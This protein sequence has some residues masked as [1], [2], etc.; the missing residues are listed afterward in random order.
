MEMTPKIADS[1][2]RS[3]AHIHRRDQGDIILG[4]YQAVERSG[5]TEVWAAGGVVCTSRM[6]ND[7]GSGMVSATL[8]FDGG[9]SILS[10]T[11]VIK[12]AGCTAWEL[13]EAYD[14][15]SMLTAS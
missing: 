14:A 5:T 11:Y 3:L 4:V 12:Q 8:D 1:I 7:L 15:E 6:I 9:E 2:V 10:R 13:I